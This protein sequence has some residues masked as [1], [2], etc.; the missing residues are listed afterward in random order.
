MPCVLMCRRL[1]AVVAARKPRTNGQLSLLHSTEYRVR[2]KSIKIGFTT[3]SCTPS[4]ILPPILGSTRILR[5]HCATV[6]IF[7]SF[8][9]GDSDGDGDG[10][11]A[12]DGGDA[13]H[14][15][16]KVIPPNDPQLMA[17]IHSYD[18]AGYVSSC[19]TAFNS[20]VLRDMY[21]AAA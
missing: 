15:R 7:R 19:V 13:G 5:A 21:G 8:D 6:L 16:S 20:A 14:T 12:A 1:Q 3:Y 4:I 11:D 9:D 18:P 10:A 17:E 2:Y